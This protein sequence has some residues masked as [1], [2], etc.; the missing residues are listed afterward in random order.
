V[1]YFGILYGQLVYFTAIWYIL[2]PLGIFYGYFMIFS[3]FGMLYG[4]KS[5]NPDRGSYL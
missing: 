3:S 4:E 2:R 1:E 5:G